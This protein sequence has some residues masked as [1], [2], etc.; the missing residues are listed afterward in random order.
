MIKPLNSQVLI[1]IEKESTITKS[2]LTQ[3]VD[4]LELER[5]KVKAVGRDVEEISKG[6]IVLFRTYSVDTIKIGK[7]T[8]TFVAEKEIFAID[9]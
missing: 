6:D 8:H 4:E 2:G 3:S 5:G 9:K 1:E 7:K